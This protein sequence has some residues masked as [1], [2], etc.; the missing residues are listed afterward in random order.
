MNKQQL[1]KDWPFDI[2]I[3]TILLRL[4]DRDPDNEWVNSRLKKIRDK[5]TSVKWD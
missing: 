4:K 2:N 3:Y 5:Y 1:E